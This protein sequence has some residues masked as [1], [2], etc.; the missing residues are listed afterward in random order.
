MPSKKNC[1]EANQCGRESGG[2]NVEELGI[3]VATTETR[4]NQINSG[5]NAGRSCWAI[6]GTLC[7]GSVHGTFAEKIGSCV[8]CSFYQRV[9]DEEK[10]YLGTRDILRKLLPPEEQEENRRKY[11]N[12]SAEAKKI[13]RLIH[14]ECEAQGESIRGETDF[15]EELDQLQRRLV[16]GEHAHLILEEFESLK[17]RWEAQGG[18]ELSQDLASKLG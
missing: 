14:Q 8:R 10:D 18:Q 5:K 9:F 17:F 11:T 4:L 2:S 7:G 16:E 6:A 1:W 12:F 13:L 15:F 3:C